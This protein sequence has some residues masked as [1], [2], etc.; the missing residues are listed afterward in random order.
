MHGVDQVGTVPAALTSFL[1]IQSFKPDLAISMGTAG[2]FSVRGAAIGDVFIG[3][4]VI[5]HD[6]RIQ[7]PVRIRVMGG[8]GE[9]NFLY[10]VPSPI[11]GEG[12]YGLD[13]LSHFLSHTVANLV[14]LLRR[15]LISMG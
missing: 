2:G 6:R 13:N 7:I 12:P 11:G 8:R 4:S 5:N 10:I 9:L 15:A 3:A 14:C 1:A